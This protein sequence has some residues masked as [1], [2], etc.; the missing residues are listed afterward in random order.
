MS[1][2][3]E[4]DRS[5]TVNISM[6]QGDYYIK[7][8]RVNNNGA[9]YT[10]PNVTEIIFQVRLNKKS[11]TK[12]IELKKSTGEIVITEG[13]MVMYFTVSKT[14]VPAKEYGSSELLIIFD[15]SKPTLW[16]DGKCTIKPRATK[17]E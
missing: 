14:D 2:L 1:V 13:Y 16:W 5:L 17:I 6:R 9:A 3:L 4:F 10:W 8:F 7:V 15:S 12:V 11:P